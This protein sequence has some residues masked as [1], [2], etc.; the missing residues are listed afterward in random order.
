ML[1]S[2][3]LTPPVR[4]TARRLGLGRAI[5]KLLALRALTPSGALTLARTRPQY[6][7]RILNVAPLEAG[8]GPIEVHMLLHHQRVF[9]GMWALY[10]FAHF[11]GVPCQMFV[12]SDGSLTSEDAACL[13]RVLPGLRVISRG[14]SDE[15]VQTVLRKRRLV[16]CLRFRDSLVFALKLFDPFF[17]GDRSS[18]VLLDSDVLFFRR[19]DELLDEREE[20]RYSPD[21]GFRYCLSPDVL[22][23]LLGRE[24]ID[25]FNP[26]VVR[27]DRG[28]LDLERVE[29]YLER[30]EF[31]STGSRPHYYA[32]LTLWAMQLTLAGARQLPD[33]YAITPTLDGM[34]PVSGHFCGGG[35]PSTWFYSRALPRLAAQFGVAP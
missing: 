1:R 20:C 2:A 24:C 21:N 3:I 31:W 30:S 23:A 27:A 13:Q 26:G 17:Y 8:D 28:V 35:L 10:S 15:R 34:L 7:R 11:S 12:H 4:R 19:P 14:D 18:F 25:A 16:N 5:V 22:H 9:E 33:T 29:Q 32:E 6:L